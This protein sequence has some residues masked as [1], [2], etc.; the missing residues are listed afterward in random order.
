MPVNED[1]IIQLAVLKNV[2]FGNDLKKVE[3]FIN[4]RPAV[5][6]DT[7]IIKGKEIT[8][9]TVNPEEYAKTIDFP[10]FQ[11][12]INVMAEEYKNRDAYVKEAQ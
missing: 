4:F 5:I 10:E 8:V 3:T 11:K 6:T 9:T 7:M 1:A 2:A 12:Q